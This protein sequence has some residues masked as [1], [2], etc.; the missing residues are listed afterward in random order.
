MS[1]IGRDDCNAFNYLNVWLRYFWESSKEIQFFTKNF[2]SNSFCLVP[3]HTWYLVM[4]TSNVMDSGIRSGV[5]P[6]DDRRCQPFNSWYVRSVSALRVRQHPQLYVLAL[7]VGE[8][9][10]GFIPPRLRNQ[11]QRCVRSLGFGWL[12][13]L[14]SLLTYLELVTISKSTLWFCCEEAESKTCRVF[15]IT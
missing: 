8:F 5:R 14:K 2:F 6:N 3:S 15:V 9:V 12:R 1:R 10:P 11:I 4:W 13:V 7:N